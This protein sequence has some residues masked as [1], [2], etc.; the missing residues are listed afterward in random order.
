MVETTMVGEAE[1]LELVSATLAGDET[2]WQQLWQAVEPTLHAVVRQPRVLGRL[3]QSED[4]CRNVAVA[5]MARLRADRFARLAQ[6]TAARQHNPALPFLA[7]LAVVTR[8][9]AIDYLRGHEAYVDRRHD[10]D[11]SSPGAWRQIGALPSDSQLTGGRPPVTGRGTAREVYAVASAELPVEQRA[12]LA[13]WLEGATF[14]EIP[15]RGAPRRA[16]KLMR[17]AVASLRRRFREEPT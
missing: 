14:D 9:V 12:A 4:D 8:R 3:A 10:R 5:V 1:V 2:A 17:A 7:W 6:Y 13:A 16:E 11:A 15:A